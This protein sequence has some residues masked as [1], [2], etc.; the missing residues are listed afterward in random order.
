MS[1]KRENHSGYREIKI[2]YSA[3]IKI[4]DN[5]DYVFQAATGNLSI[6]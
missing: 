5:Y 6:N 1:K 3:P 2:Q 4:S